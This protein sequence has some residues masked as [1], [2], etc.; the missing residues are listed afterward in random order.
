MLHVSEMSWTRHIKHPGEL[1]KL[2]DK[3]STKILSLDPNEKKI[4]LGLKQLQDNPW[5]TL[6]EKYTEEYTQ[7]SGSKINTIWS[8][9]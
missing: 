7:R 8:F 1:F 4:S 5:D 2:G 3:L 9:C 6:E